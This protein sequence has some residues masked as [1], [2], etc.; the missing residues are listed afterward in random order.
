MT[1]AQVAM[2][3]RLVEEYAHLLRPDM[4]QAQ[5][6]RIREAGIENL[7][8]GWAG[9]IEPGR[10]HYYR[11]HGPTVLI[12][13]DNVQSNANHIH[14]VWRDLENDFGD[15]VLRRHYETAPD[16]HGH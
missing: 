7:Y 4:A 1:E 3:W 8:F 13:Y 10:P 15:D 14:T 9:S 12:E 5:L 11:I 6:A 2:L 16:G